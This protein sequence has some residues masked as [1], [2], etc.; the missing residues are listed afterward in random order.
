MSSRSKGLAKEK[1]LARILTSVGYRVERAP[2]T[3]RFI[4]KGRIVSVASDFFGSV[5]IEAI[6]RRTPMLLIQACDNGNASHRRRKIEREL[7]PFQPHGSC[8]MLFTWGRSKRKGYRW[9]AQVAS[10]GGWVRAGH[11]RMNGKIENGTHTFRRMMAPLEVA[12]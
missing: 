4:G 8:V 3:A 10:F 2:L 7:L 5:D 11:L 12:S 6:R 9:T 1:A